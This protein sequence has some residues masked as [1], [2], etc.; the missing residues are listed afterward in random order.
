MINSFNAFRC[1]SIE[2]GPVL[3]S[4]AVINDFG[5]GGN[6]PLKSPIHLSNARVLLDRV[7]KRHAMPP[8]EY[9]TLVS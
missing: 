4:S 8:V 7:G 3:G 2:L 1:S 9:E 5:S 6:A